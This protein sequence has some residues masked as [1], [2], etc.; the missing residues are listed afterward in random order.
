M[1]EKQIFVSAVADNHTTDK[2]GVGRYRWIG[3]KCYLYVYNGTGAAMVVGRPYFHGTSALVLTGSTHLEEVFT[4]GQAGKGTSPD[5]LAGIAMSAIPIANYGWIQVYGY[6][7]ALLALAP[8]AAAEVQT[9]TITGT[10][11]GGTFNIGYRGMSSGTVAFNAS[12]ANVVT[13]LVAMLNIGAAGVT[14]SGGALPGAAVV[15]TFAAAPG[16][17]NMYE[18]LLELNLAGLTGGT[19]VA[20]T[21]VRTTQGSSGAP[22]AVGDYLCGQVGGLTLVRDTAS[23]SGGANRRRIKCFTATTSATVVTVAGFIECL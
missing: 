12:A 16:N 14:A 23:G 20:G 5:S 18:P 1:T 19:A 3:N 2:E 4:L 6:N 9:I 8:A 10:P 17:V 21:V 7:A 22:I 15:V 11:T 13:A